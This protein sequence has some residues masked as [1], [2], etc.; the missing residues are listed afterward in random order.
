MKNKKN[1]KNTRIKSMCGNVTIMVLIIGLVIIV[2]ITALTKFMFE[3][4]IFA[5]LDESKLKAL[6]IAE[7]GISNMF[8]EIEKFHNDE[9]SS[10][11]SNPYS[12]DVLN[13]DSEIIGSFTVEYE[14]I[15]NDDG[16]LTN[17]IITSEGT[18]EYSGQARKIQVNLAVSFSTEVDIFGY[19]YSKGGL[20][21][22][23]LINVPF[24]NGPLYVGEDL[25]IRDLIQLGDVVD[26][27]KILVGGNIDLEGYID[28]GGPTRIRSQMINVAGDIEMSGALIGSTL[29]ESNSSVVTMAL[30]V[31]GDIRMSGSSRIGSSSNPVDLSC[32]GS[33]STGTGSNIYYNSPIGDDIFDPPKLN[34]GVY[35]NNFIS[36]IQEPPSDVLVIDEDDMTDGVFVIDPELI[37][38]EPPPN[39]VFLRANGDN[40]ISFE[41]GD[42]GSYYLEVEGNVLINGDIR[43]GEEIEDSNLDSPDND[44]YYSG[45]GK[46]IATGNIDASCGL[47][48]DSVSDFPT[49][50]LL[51]LMPLG[52]LDISVDDYNHYLAD[53]EDPDVY[54]LGIAGGSAILSSHNAVLGSLIC[55]QINAT[56][57]GGFLGYLLGSFATI[58]Y[59]EN[60]GDS[61]PE[62]LPKLVYGGVT[63]SKQWEEVID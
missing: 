28:I 8:S 57:E 40:Y 6:N 33:I 51:I 24:I 3:D 55:N 29:I 44:I 39:D 7:A 17:Y 22:F 36:Q 35:V 16:K 62:D 18:D 42:D 41:Q 20:E 31:M 2:A 60:L 58:G 63:F 43:I 47:V 23:D 30:I 27:D 25:V 9:I 45:K 53:Y 37:P 59:Q 5:K 50:S 14:E 49:N 32:H 52:D 21:F 15:Y 34:V 61:I 13:S 54:I 19:I 1:R 10:L 48:P 26:S 46:L 56:D 38:V 11:P 4:I 12:E